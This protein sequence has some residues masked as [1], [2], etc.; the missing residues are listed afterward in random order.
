MSQNVKKSVVLTHR[1]SN[2]APV[3]FTDPYLTV[4]TCNNTEHATSCSQ[5][6]RQA[7]AKLI[8]IAV[9]IFLTP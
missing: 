1:Q 2:P 7:I 8:A 6:V 9:L 3:R 4:V 5:N